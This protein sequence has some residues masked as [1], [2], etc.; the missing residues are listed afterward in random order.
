MSIHFTHATFLKSAFKP[1]DFPFAKAEIAFAGRSNVGK[2]STLNLLT[3]QHKLAKVSKTP[4]RTT[5]INFFTLE[6]DVF[7]VDLPGYGYAKVSHEVK[8]HWQKFLQDYILKREALCGIVLVMDCRHP[9]TELDQV[10]L[11]LCHMGNRPCHVLLNKADKLSNN[12][13]T[14]LLKKTVKPFLESY[15]KLSIQFFSAVKGQGVVEL[16]A[17]LQDWLSRPPNVTNVT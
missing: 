2:S 15:D 12:D 7:L 6:E 9:F 13:K 11:D 5:S 8:A 4:G 16:K 1:N 14:T 3:G 10:F 17:K